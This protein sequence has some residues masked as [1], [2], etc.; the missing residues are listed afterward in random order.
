[1]KNQPPRQLRQPTLLNLL[2]QRQLMKLRQ[3]QSGQPRNQWH[4]RQLNLSSQ[5]HPHQLKPQPKLNP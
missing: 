5:Q 2:H 3:Q 4:R 1:M